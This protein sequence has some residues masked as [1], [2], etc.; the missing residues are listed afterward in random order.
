MWNKIKRY[1]LPFSIAIAIPVAV[2]TISALLTKNNMNIY[3][4]INTPPLSPPS[5]VFPIVW[6]ILYALMGIS[7][8]LIFINRQNKSEAYESALYYYGLSLF[9]NFLWSII[10]FNFGAFLLALIC[11]SALLYFVIKTII[12]YK[13]IYAPAAYLQI[14]YVVWVAFAWYLNFGIFLLNM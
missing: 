13:K 11:L 8:A 1:I 6:A 2:G 10:F 9:A 7:S 14:P 4:K 3:D 5:L 12:I